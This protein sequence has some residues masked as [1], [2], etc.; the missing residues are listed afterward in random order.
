LYTLNYNVPCGSDLIHHWTFDNTTLDRCGFKNLLGTPLYE[1]GFSSRKALKLDGTYHL[2]YPSSVYFFSNFTVSFW[3]KLNSDSG[4]I[5]DFAVSSSDF[6]NRIQYK[7]GGGNKLELLF[8]PGTKN[9][10]PK[11]AFITYSFVP[12]QWIQITNTFNSAIESRSYINGILSKTTP[13]SG[14]IVGGVTRGFSVLGS[15]I[16]YFDTMHFSLCDFRIYNRVL[17][18]AEVSSII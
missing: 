7:F 8:Y 15:D 12:G 9:G 11:S 10:Q 4:S 5:F 3:V 2:K 13:L 6:S 17:T 14:T 18:N 16:S 1:D